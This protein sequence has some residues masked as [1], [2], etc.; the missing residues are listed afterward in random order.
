MAAFASGRGGS[1]MPT[2]ASSVRSVT[3]PIRS[4]P[5]PARAASKVA[6]SRSRWATTMTRSPEFAILSLASSARC[7][8]SSVTGTVVPSGDR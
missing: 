3:S 8:F 7:R 5:P 1:T 2:I 4:P 6:G